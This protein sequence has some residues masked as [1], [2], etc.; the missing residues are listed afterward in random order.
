MIPG[1][2]RGRMNRKE[3]D[4]RP[5][6]RNRCT[7]KAA[8]EPRRMATMV[9]PAAAFTDKSS[10]CCISPSWIVGLN[11]LVVQSVIGQP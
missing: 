4:S 10:A 3:I 11:H 8:A 7:A 9:A 6:N 5:K 1:S 2:A